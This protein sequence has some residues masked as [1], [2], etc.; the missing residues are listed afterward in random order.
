MT[1]I[2][3]IYSNDRK[4]DIKV[5]FIFSFSEASWNNPSIAQLIERGTV[6]KYDKH[7]VGIA[8]SLV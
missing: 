8:R 3:P 2:R 7:V 1:A 4:K 5:V 6:A